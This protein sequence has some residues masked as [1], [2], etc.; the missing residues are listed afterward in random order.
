M[1]LHLGCGRKHLDGYVNVDGRATP[2]ADVIL[3]L[4][5]PW[6]W[7]QG[8]VDEIVAHHLLE[9]FHDLP[10]FMDKAHR[11]L[12]P[13]GVM[14]VRVP[15][16]RHRNADTDPTHVRRFTEHSMDYWYPG[17]SFEG[18]SDLQWQCLHHAVVGGLRVPVLWRLYAPARH[19]YVIAPHELH[20]E[21]T[22]CKDSPKADGQSKKSSG[23]NFGK[24]GPASADAGPAGSG[25]RPGVSEGHQTDV[26]QPFGNLWG[27]RL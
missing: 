11:V 13:G 27:G 3:D 23:F 5:G 2:A 14:D 15:H 6:P 1:R 19:W 12:R 24:P 7:T 22:P 17:T 10:A 25:S 16:H 4:E 21:L 9:H 20:W 8:S 18:F 26:S